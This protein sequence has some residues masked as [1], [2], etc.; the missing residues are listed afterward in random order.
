MNFREDVRNVA[1]IAH[2]DHGKTTLV[3]VLLRQSG[4]FR[5]NQVIAERV[6]DSN[7]LEKERGIT[8]LSKNTAIPYKDVKINVIDTP[9]HADFGGEVER[10]LKMADGAILV[11]DAF[12][13]PMP[14]TKFVLK[15]ALELGL[16]IIV[17][18]NKV[19]RP[20]GRAL[21]VVDEVL[22]LFMELEATEEQLNSL[23]VFASAKGG[24]ASLDLDAALKGNAKDMVPL[25]DA[26]LEHINPPKGDGDAPLQMLVST[27]DYSEYLGKI[28]IGKIANGTV[29]TGDEVII[30]N[31]HDP[32]K[33]DKLRITKLYEFEGLARIEVNQA[34]FGSIVAVSGAPDIIIG[35]TICDINNPEPLAF[36]KISEPTLAIN[37]MVNDSPLAGTE[38]KFVTS[39]QVR[40]RLYKETNTDVGLKV[41]D[42][43]SAECF[44]V[45]G[46]GELHFSIL[47]ET[48]RR[49][50]YEFQ[51]SKPQVLFRDIDGEKQEPYELVTI[52]VPEEF[53]GVVIEKLGSRKG[54]LTNMQ[55][56]NET[57][58]RL[59]FSIPSRGLI[60]YRGE[61][62]TDTKGSGIFNS[63]FDKYDAYKGDISTRNVGS[64]VAFE[65]GEATTYALHSAQERGALFISPGDK[66]YKGM[67][68]GQNNRWDD[69]KINACKKKQATNF[70]AAG[71]DDAQRLTPPKTLSIESGLMFIGDDELLEVTPLNIR[72]RKKKLQF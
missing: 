26:I 69:M 6:M 68:I 47:I 8:I 37:F 52:D 31:M 17:C 46:R 13:G 50:G 55:P 61:F 53:T 27:I 38:G 5:D 51:L 35:D 63:I 39:R 9:G 3:D 29:K 22:E 62:L 20:E 4:I 30:M 19:D 70:R 16:A 58:M 71:K 25:Y 34:K 42:T 41:E 45:S 67:V 40:D 23:F 18:I 54:D 72:A 66:V 64:L 59:T 24:F 7:D 14:Q 36:A 21:E 48:M 44:K 33:K 43:D 10:V 65:P 28:G 49:E 12:E 32:A 2:V 57:T 60:G 56:L 11:V 15:N 1:I